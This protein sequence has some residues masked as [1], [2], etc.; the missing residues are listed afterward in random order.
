MSIKVISMGT[1]VQSDECFLVVVKA[2]AKC[3]KVFIT[4]LF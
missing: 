1:S 2:F 3:G 4:V